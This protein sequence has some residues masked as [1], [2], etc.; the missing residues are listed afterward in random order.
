MRRTCDNTLENVELNGPTKEKNAFINLY[1]ASC[2]NY[3]TRKS[4]STLNRISKVCNEKK[5]NEQLPEILN[6]TRKIK[7]WLSSSLSLSLCLSRG[8]N[9]W[10]VSLRRSQRERCSTLVSPCWFFRVYTEFYRVHSSRVH[11]PYPSLLRL[12]SY[13]YIHVC[14]CVCVSIVLT[15]RYATLLGLFLAICSF[16]LV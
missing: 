9:S 10:K 11:V 5:R 4:F 1:E 2:V 14:V 3:F 15:K 6:E 16:W 13:K 12:Y 7:V 8:W